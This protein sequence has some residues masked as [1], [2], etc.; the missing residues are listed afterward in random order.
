MVALFHFYCLGTNRQGK[1][2]VS[3]T[4]AEGWYF[5][6]QQCLDNRNRIFPRRGR[7]TRPVG[8]KNTIGFEG[9]NRL[10]GGRGRDNSDLAATLCQQAQN[11]AFHAVVYGNN[12][13]LMGGLFAVAFVPLPIGLIP[14]VAFFARDQRH[15]V[16]S[17]HRRERF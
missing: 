6:C 3:Q 5:L 13:K 15:E 14:T 4:N 17:V 1:H 8:E 9:Q 10:C 11:V 2:L 16:L 12:M 7:I